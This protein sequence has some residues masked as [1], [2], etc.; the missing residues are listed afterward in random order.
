MDVTGASPRD[1]AGH[2]VRVV[3]RLFSPSARMLSCELRR[4]DGRFQ[5][6]VAAGTQEIVTSDAPELE[7]LHAKAAEWRTALEAHGYVPA[8]DIRGTASARCS[9]PSEG[10]TAFRSLVECAELLSTEDRDAA[11]ALRHHATT[12]LVAIGLQDAGMT[13]DA[14][15]LS[16]LALQRVNAGSADVQPLLHACETLLARIEAT[17]APPAE[18]GN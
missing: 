11:H 5:L 12:G 3:W 4:I 17:L 8:D 1:A 18:P 13:C 6:I 14:I 16:R 15:A 10:R 2:D 9:L 7:P